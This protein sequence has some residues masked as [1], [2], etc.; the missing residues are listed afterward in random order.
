MSTFPA[1]N[2]GA[3]H[4]LGAIGH[5]NLRA[6]VLRIGRRVFGRRALENIG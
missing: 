3:R 2:K 4:L 1:E 6:H 5:G